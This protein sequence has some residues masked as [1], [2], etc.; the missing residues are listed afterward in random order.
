MLSYS[1]GFLR[2]A[3]HNKGRANREP[4]LFVDGNGFKFGA[5]GIINCFDKKGQVHYGQPKLLAIVRR[6]PNCL[7]ILVGVDKK[8]RLPDNPNVAIIPHLNSANDFSR[9][10]PE[11]HMTNTQSTARPKIAAICTEVRK[12]AHAQHFLD[13]FLEGYGWDNRHYRPPID[14]VSLYVDQVP[15]GDLSRERA[16]RFPTMQIYPTV[17]DALTLGSD[18]LAVDGVLLIGEHGDYGRNE[19]GQRLYPRYELFKQIVAVYRLAG[20]SVPIFNDKH[21][22]WRWDWAKEM[23]DC[24]REMGFALMAGSSLPV[25]WRTPSVDLPLG[26]TVTEALCICYGGVDS[27]D[28]HGLETLQCMVERR[29]GGESGVKW[30]QAYRDDNVWQAYHDGLWSRELFE[31]ALSRSHTLTPSRPGFNNNFPTF[32]EMREL[33]KEPVA[34]HYEHVD[35]LRCTML[36]LNGLV[37][38]FN[39]AA[40]L[41]DG[42]IC[43]TQMY[44]PMP[45]ARTTLA[46]FFSPQVNHVEQ[47]FLTGNEPYPAERTLLTTGLTE[48]GVDSLH[49]GEVRVET[50]HLNITYQPNPESTFWRESRPSLKPAPAPLQLSAS[51]GE[52]DGLSG[53]A[54]EPLRIAVIATIYRERSHAQHFCDR[55]HTGYPVGGRWHRPNIEIAS[56][57]VDQRPLGDQSVDRAREFGFQVYPT[58]AE[59]LRCG[60][61]ELAVDGVLIMGEHGEYP[62]N[63]KGQKLYP[64]YEFFQE[65]VQVFA[66]DGRSVPVYNDKHL[67]YSFE[68]ASKMV[69]D[70]HRLGFPLL[71]GSSLPV[72]WRLPDIEL[73]LGCAIEEALMV[74]VGGS[75]PM[76]YHALEAMQSMVERRKGG[77]TGVRAVQLIGG[78]EVWRAGEA[79]RWSK[80][81]LEAA[82]SRSDTPQGFTV[83]DG[84]T[85]DLLGSSELMRLV[86]NPAAYLIEYNDGLR[87]TLLMLNG[88]VKDYCFATQLR[89][90]P[91]PVSTQFFLTPGPNVTYSACLVSKI[92]EMLVTNVAPYPAERTLI[93][94]GML[95]SCLT[96]K[97]QNHQRL[98]TP[99]LAVTYQAPTESH[100][101]QW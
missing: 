80:M 88:A 61:D 22:S 86:E 2:R 9:Q 40:H 70:S 5:I 58:I 21:L 14:L 45:P 33:V 49:Q 55:F 17:A 36:L 98:E 15:E 64:R 35:G 8:I 65:C 78:D 53:D 18:T 52:D 99:H 60:G 100:H 83:E 42:A 1:D 94:S 96:S 26:S 7:V 46:N 74:G 59:A 48:V 71:S 84:R 19:K 57:Y 75:D 81:L 93:V 54:G 12:Y 73:P 56:L 4:S 10:L 87:A 38:D 68:K 30:L 25:T 16:A 72:T 41:E 13:R 69:T 97:V 6:L 79:G 92:E 50:P 82:L 3:R 63:E 95:E 34:Y 24:S 67:S 27:Y 91:L 90:D 11:P 76:D 39:F 37:Q 29:K 32:D 66:E 44:L 77:E 89:D 62:Y 51:Q 43:S 85:Q 31:S 20:R 47:M 28:F 23:F 101:A